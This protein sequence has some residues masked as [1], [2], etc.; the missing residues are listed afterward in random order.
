M[1]K[2]IIGLTKVMDKVLINDKVNTMRNHICENLTLQTPSAIDVQLHY[3]YSMEIYLAKGAGYR[4]LWIWGQ[5]LTRYL[6]KI[7]MKL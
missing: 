3:I 2:L 5:N 4:I 1:V 6:D 7:G